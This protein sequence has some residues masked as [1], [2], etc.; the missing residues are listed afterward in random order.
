MTGGAFVSGLLGGFTGRLEVLDSGLPFEPWLARRFRERALSS[1][2]AV[3]VPMHQD[4]VEFESLEGSVARAR[5]W[6]SSRPVGGGSWLWYGQLSRFRPSDLDMPRRLARVEGHSARSWPM[7]YRELEPH[8]AAVERLLQPYGCSYGMAPQSYAQADCREY[9]ERPGPSHFERVVMDRLVSGGLRPHIGQTALGGRAW[10]VH[11]VSPLAVEDSAWAHPFSRRRTWIGHLLEIAVRTTDVQMYPNTTVVRVLVEHGVTQG[12]EAVELHADGT[13]RTVSIR[14]PLVV[15][16]A[17]AL[18]TVR[19]LLSSE[20][21]DR[22]RLIGKSFTFTQERVAYLPS[23]IRRSEAVDDLRM[24][25]FAN[26][27]LKEFY[28]PVEDG[29]PVKCG[30]FALYDGYAAELPYRHVRNLRLTGRDLSTFLARERER[31]AVKVS[32]KGESL[33]WLGKYLALSESR[34]RLGIPTIR[35]HYEAHP[36]DRVIQD[37]AERIIVRLGSILKADTMLLHDV[38]VGRDIISAHQHGGAIFGE[39]P[40]VGVVDADGECFDARGLFLADSS[41]MPTSGAT[42]STLTAMALARRLAHRLTPTPAQPEAQADH[43]P[44]LLPAERRRQD[45]FGGH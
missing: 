4:W 13:T 9:V 33:P 32:F 27:S 29:A 1:A 6:W 23:D 28:D 31:Y 17:G 36:Y 22:G 10:D 26:V 35:I 43:A 34:N 44:P 20:L 39:R 21:P 42:N 40:D 12:V 2:S 11:P 5:K 45:D 14:S 8:Y 30:K 41:V 18:E 16:G 7:E 37:Y 15:L 25:M 3:S 19:I 24:G 38:P